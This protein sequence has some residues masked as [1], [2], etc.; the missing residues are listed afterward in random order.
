MTTTLHIPPHPSP[1]HLT[2]FT[3]VTNASH[4]RAQL[5]AANP[6][7]AYALLDAR[8]LL[9]L[10]HLLA[11]VFRALADARAQRLKTRSLHA[12]IVYA[13]A[14]DTNIA[15][16]LRAFGVADATTSLLC[17]KV[18]EGGDVA[19]ERAAV[20]EFL[21]REVQGTPAP[22]DALDALGDW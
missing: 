6:A 13:L 20:Q 12:E 15:A 2:L 7:F 8:A 16:A 22:I 1:I 4:L 19:A 5:L 17:V 18:G 21:A 14:R 3:S 11:A 10:P 9:S